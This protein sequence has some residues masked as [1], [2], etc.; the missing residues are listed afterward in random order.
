MSTASGLLAS[1]FAVLLGTHGEALGYI[2]KD[3]VVVT[4]HGEVVTTEGGKAVLS[5]P[6]ETAITGIFDDAYVSVAALGAEVGA[7]QI[8]AIVEAEEVEGI[9]RGA[10]IV[11][12]G[13]HYYVT[14]PQEPALDGSQ[15]LILSKQAH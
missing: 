11:R 4:E 1:G 9:E 12:G 14:E 5:E 13:V 2:P 8:A 10:V 15:V 7:V 3:Q 6:T